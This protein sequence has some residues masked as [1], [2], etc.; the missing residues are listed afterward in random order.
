MS[1]GD[2]KL[3]RVNFPEF[4]FGADANETYCFRLPKDEHGNN[5]QGELVNIGLSITETFACDGTAASVELGSTSDADA[6]AKLTIADAAADN[7]CFDVSDDTDA[8]ISA[9]IAAGA[10]LKVTLTQSTD[11]SSDAGKGMPFFDFYVWN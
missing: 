2:K 8:I 5:Q 7:D 11:G 10:L 3:V 9:N 6:Y 4:D 1:Y